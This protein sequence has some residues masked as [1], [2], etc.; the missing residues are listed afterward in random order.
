MKAVSTGHSQTLHSR[1]LAVARY[2]GLACAVDVVCLTPLGAPTWAVSGP[3][4]GIYGQMGQQVLTA[5]LRLAIQVQ[6]GGQAIGAWVD[7]QPSH[8][9]DWGHFQLDP[10]AYPGDGH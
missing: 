5:A 6:W 7:G 2:G 1:H 3:D 4:G 10:S 9:R 8:F